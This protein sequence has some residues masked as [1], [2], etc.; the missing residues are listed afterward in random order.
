MLKNILLISIIF[1]FIFGCQGDDS[2]NAFTM[3]KVSIEQVDTSTAKVMWQSVTN[4]VTSHEEMGYEVY[5]SQTSEFNPDTTTLY[6]T[7]FGV[8]EVKIANLEVGQTYYVLVIAM[9]K[10][11]NQTPERNYLAIT[12]SKISKSDLPNLSVMYVTD[13]NTDL[14]IIITNAG[15]SRNVRSLSNSSV[16]DR[17][18][19]EQICRKASIT[20]S[21]QLE[22]CISDVP[23]FKDDC[24]KSGINNEVLLEN[25]IIEAIYNSTQ[26]D[27]ETFAIF[28]PKDDD[29]I[30]TGIDSVVLASN[31]DQSK[32]VQVEF[33][34][35]FL[36]S[37]MKFPD[38]SIVKFSNYSDDGATVSYEGLNGTFKG[39]I[40]FPPDIKPSEIQDANKKLVEQS[41]KPRI[42]NTR[43]CEA[44]IEASMKLVDGL[45]NF[46]SGLLSVLACG[47]STTAAVL[48]GGVAIPLAIWACGSIVLNG[49]NTMA[50]V[51]T[52]NNSPL[53]PVN[54]LNSA[55][56]T[57][58]SCLTGGV[59]GCASGLG[60][61]IY[62]LQRNSGGLLD[63]KRLC[64]QDGPRAGV[65]GD[66]HLYT[67]DKLSYDFQAVGEFIF[68]KSNIPN[69]SFEVQVRLMPVG[70]RTD[71]SV[72]QAVAMNVGG[73]R[74]GLYRGQDPM[75]YI[76]GV[77]NELPDN[78]VSL[79]NGGR[80]IKSG[81]RYSVSWPDGNGLVELR[82]RV[83]TIYLGE[84]QEGNVMGLLGNADG[85]PKNDITTR[86]GNN[87]GTNLDFY[88]LY[89]GY[90]NSWRISQEESL[91]DY[92]PGEN[93]ETFTVY[94]FPRTLARVSDLDAATYAVA[95][96][97]CLEAGITGKTF[98]EE[99]I[100][101]VALT[102]DPEFAELV[103]GFSDPQANINI[104]AP[105][106]PQLGTPNFGQLNGSVYGAVNKPLINGAEAKLT[107]S[108]LPLLGIK[109]KF[110]TNGLYQTDVVPIG[111]GYQLNITANEYISEIVFNLNV[112]NGRTKE[113]EPI[114]LIPNRYE[115][116]I[117]SIT[118]IVRNAIN[119]DTLSDI[120]INVRRYINKRMGEIIQTTKT[121]SNGKFQLKN[122][123]SGNY[124]LE[125]YDEE[126]STNYLTATNIGGKTTDVN[127]AMS[128]P[129]GDALYRI[130]LT[131]NNTDDLDA[132]L[133][134][135]NGR[136]GRFHAHFNR[137][138][139][140]SYDEEPYAWLDRDDKDGFGPESVTI[141]K[142]QYGGDYRYSVHDYIN[143]ASTSAN[144]LANSGA[145][146]DIYSKNGLEESFTVP[147]I[148]GTLWTVFEIDRNGVII[149][150]SNIG[151]EVNQGGNYSTMSRNQPEGSSGQTSPNYSR[152]YQIPF[153]N[154]AGQT[155]YLPITFQSTK[156]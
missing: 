81:S 14:G 146:V 90:A 1:P 83:S 67:F 122:L 50:N 55:T 85:D 98:I 62:D 136:G 37:S 53:D 38:G 4:D 149:P 125:V 33:G 21:I 137:P 132:H 152:D 54:E 74:V 51:A 145:K 59:S 63:P 117:G 27:E 127:I 47:T 73:D 30:L 124:T 32:N 52:K 139:T 133:T 80:V 138:G 131:W 97:I 12:I 116:Q 44:I 70:N 42:P 93:T 60:K 84:S 105:P 113:V 130:V 16:Q 126:F 143:S 95:E 6:T 19:A 20:D 86:S 100:L 68:T 61:A 150:V 102:G 58:Y 99:C 48:S 110:T 108:G 134:G 18:Y 151:Y 29:G 49:I 45:V 79:P 69:D 65:K 78:S 3:G 115:G 57:A 96:K 23:I 26:E 153:S 140:T 66:P 41:K 64:N 111:S 46:T 92:A 22:K 31:T 34:D 7:V 75:L 25:C 89:P 112:P 114:Y 87:L 120:S 56:S 13:K 121:D 43:E 5:V 147:N 40:I 77:P 154:N 156:N 119:N 88:T 8:T 24:L 35:D 142:L 82:G 106:L 109:P 129:L 72:L 94:N 135:P 10:G 39:D 17:N 36:P 118:G 141:S 155:D 76:N 104:T 107:I 28:G 101:D 144:K 103:E 128:P 11:G 9:D 148:A 2:G 71:V 91:F 15:Q 123:N